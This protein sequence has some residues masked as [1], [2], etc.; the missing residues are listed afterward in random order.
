MGKNKVFAHST[1]RLTFFFILAVFTVTAGCENPWMKRATAPLYKDKD[2]TL[3][4]GDTGPG[5]GI[6]FYFDPA[7]FTMTDTGLPAH[8]LEAAPVDQGTYLKWASTAYETT[9]IGTG[10]AIGTGRDNTA[11]ILAADPTA[12]AALACDSYNNGGE[13]DWFLPSKDELDKLYD[14]RT[15]FSIPPQ[16]F[17]SSSEFTYDSAAAESFL[18]STQA[19]C[20]KNL[21]NYVR[22]V[23]AF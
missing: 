14:Q 17:W 4:L 3:S 8:Y 7:G 10:T 1:S 9:L 21:P 13:D 2:G 15:L 20:F 6:I 18:D 19:N 5:G 11:R 22:A 23:R 16:L 12:P